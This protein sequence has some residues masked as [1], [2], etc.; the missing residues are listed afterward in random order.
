MT[1]LLLPVAGRS[2]RFPDMRPKWL[3]SFPDG[4]MMIEKAIDHLDLSEVDDIY[5]VCLQEHLD[6][7]IDQE[8]LQ[9]ILAERSQKNI[10]VVSL[11]ASGC[12]Y[13]IAAD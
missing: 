6:K 2:S 10:H 7:F 3:L 13:Q 9:R 12:C 11:F 4:L 5:V 8:T 1:N